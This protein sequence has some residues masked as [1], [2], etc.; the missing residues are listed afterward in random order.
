[1]LHMF[2]LDLVYLFFLLSSW[3]F[4]HLTEEIFEPRAAFCVT[5]FSS[6]VRDERCWQQSRGTGES[7]SGSRPMR[8]LQPG[9]KRLSQTQLS[10]QQVPLQV[11][12]SAVW[13]GKCWRNERKIS[14]VIYAFFLLPLTVDSVSSIHFCTSGLPCLW[15]TGRGASSGFKSSI[16]QQ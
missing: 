3:L 12:S 11:S 2:S 15:Q 8:G 7:A 16:K 9:K 1:M 10:V 6:T 14:E 5:A 4:L 13:K